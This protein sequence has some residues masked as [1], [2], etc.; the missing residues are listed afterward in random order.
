[1]KN[2]RQYLFPISIGFL[3][4]I[5]FINIFSFMQT[6]ELAQFQ[7]FDIETAK[8][9]QEQLEE[10][11]ATLKDDK[12][13]LSAELK[14]LEKEHDAAV[15]ASLQSEKQQEQL[16]NDIPKLVKEKEKALKKNEENYTMRPERVLSEDDL[17][18]ALQLVKKGDL[19]SYDMIPS[20]EDDE[21]VVLQNGKQML[22]F[23]GYDRFLALFEVEGEEKDSYITDL[24]IVDVESDKLLVSE[25]YGHQ[26][27]H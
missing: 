25:N 6:K 1:M 12:K 19:S 7:R 10:T 23:V 8:G 5:V 13:S 18:K 14:E 21:V 24:H 26:K 15:E 2:I 11:L 27:V 22:A 16:A 4:L 17:Q 3:V 20:A 9:E